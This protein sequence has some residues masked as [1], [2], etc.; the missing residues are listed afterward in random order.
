V[1]EPKQE[2]GKGREERGGR[3]GEGGRK[4]GYQGKISV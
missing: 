1:K 4:K 2:G 3:K